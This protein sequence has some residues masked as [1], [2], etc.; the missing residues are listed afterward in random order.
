MIAI[1]F[2]LHNLEPSHGSNSLLPYGYSSGATEGRQSFNLFAYK[3]I[4]SRSHANVMD[5]C[6]KKLFNPLDIQASS[7][8]KL[9][10]APNRRDVTFPTRNDFIF[11]LSNMQMEDEGFAC[12]SNCSWKT[13]FGLH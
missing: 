13:V 6:A 2:T 3:G 8:G 9:L 12:F 5:W 11:N 1:R 10:V 7:P 4:S